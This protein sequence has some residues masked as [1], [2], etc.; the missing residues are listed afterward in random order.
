MSKEKIRLP[1]QEFIEF[2]KWIEVINKII[3]YKKE[4]KIN[5]SYIEN[6]YSYNQDLTLGNRRDLII[7]GRMRKLSSLGTL[8]LS[9]SQKTI[10][11][12]LFFARYFYFKGL[13]EGLL[14]SID[15]LFRNTPFLFGEDSK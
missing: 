3:K 7:L 13:D 15:K 12:Q 9:S 2:E 8:K 10:L 11:N 14:V 4:N 6:Y 1:K 5:L